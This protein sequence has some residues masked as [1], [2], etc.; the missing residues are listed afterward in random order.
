MEAWLHNIIMMPPFRDRCSFRLV[1]WEEHQPRTH[2]SVGSGLRCNHS[3]R[4]GTPLCTRRRTCLNGTTHKPNTSAILCSRLPRMLQT[5]PTRIN[6]L[7]LKAS[8]VGSCRKL[9]RLPSSVV[10]LLPLACSGSSPCWSNCSCPPSDGKAQDL[11]KSCSALP[12]T[13]EAK[14]TMTKITRIKSGPPPEGLIHP[15]QGHLGRAPLSDALRRAS[16]VAA[17]AGGA[18]RICR[19]GVATAGCARAARPI[20]EKAV[21]RGLRGPLASTRRRDLEDWPIESIARGK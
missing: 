2:S 20:A 15:Q 12:A 1:L 14:T 13:R 18:K 21:R 10:P 3:C 4:A 7:W 6:S 17:K 9:V 5:K 11:W 16:A 19:V 8:H